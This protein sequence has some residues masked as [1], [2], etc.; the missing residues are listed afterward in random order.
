MLQTVKKTFIF[1]FKFALIL[2]IFG[3]LFWNASKATDA[4]GKNV[5]ELLWEQPKRWD[6]LGAAFLVQLFA[7]STT[8]F[9]WRWLVQTLGLTLSVKD[10]FRLGFLGLMLNLA[11]M[12]IVGGDLIKSYLIAKK[13]PDYMSQAVAS[14]IVD[15]IVGLLVMFLCGSIFVC[16]TGFA[17]RQEVLART[18]SQIVFILTGIGYICVGIVF[19]PFFS[20]GHV[21]RLLAKIPFCGSTLE[22]LT[23]SFLLYRNRKICLLKAFAITFLVHIP[24]G[25][26]LYLIAQGLFGSVPNLIDHIMLYNVVNLTAMIPLAAGPFEFVLEQVYPLFSVDGVKMGIGIGL[27]VALGYRLISILVAGLGIIYYLS[28]RD[29]IKEVAG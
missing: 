7:V 5:F 15:R 28:S 20:K 16:L 3:F 23:R 8:I 1:C 25:I 9:R 27:V 21:E 17:F 29:E 22:K 11:P 26:S 6:L 14:V 4:D 12:G 18:F 13:N 10:A 24:F 19:L 2:G